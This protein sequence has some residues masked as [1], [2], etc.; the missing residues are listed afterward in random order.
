MRTFTRL[1]P[2]DCPNG[3]VHGNVVLRDDAAVFAFR[4][5]AVRHILGNLDIS[6]VVFSNGRLELVQGSLN[7]GGSAK[8]TLPGLKLVSESLVVG[9]T[10]RS[11]LGCTQ[12]ERS[13]EASGDAELSLPDCKC[14][15]QLNGAAVTISSRA[16]VDA[17]NCEAVFGDV[18][19]Q[20][21]AMF[22]APDIVR[23]SAVDYARRQL[24]R[25]SASRTSSTSP[26]TSTAARRRRRP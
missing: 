22:L 7:I 4:E 10:S 26:D 21:G 18:R 23:M 11:T 3:T 14:I 25:E 13:L 12:V 5:A 15:G 6:S 17:R 2:S 9:G 1:Q 16:K 19:V 20:D 24:E 8:V